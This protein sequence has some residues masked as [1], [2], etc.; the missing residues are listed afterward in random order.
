[1]FSKAQQRKMDSRD[2]DPVHSG[3]VCLEHSPAAGREEFTCE[4]KCGLR[5]TID[6]FSRSQRR[7]GNYV[8]LFTHRDDFTY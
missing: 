2:F 6:H 4:G 5:K 8:G 3:M 7:N 1:M